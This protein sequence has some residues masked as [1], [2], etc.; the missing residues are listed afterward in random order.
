MSMGGLVVGENIC[1]TAWAG[2][3]FSYVQHGLVI[4]SLELYEGFAGGICTQSK[5]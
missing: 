4:Y 5:L 1:I 2:N 3:T